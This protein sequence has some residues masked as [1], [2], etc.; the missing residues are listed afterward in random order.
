MSL[1][2]A[3]ALSTTI[4]LS[5]AT[6]GLVCADRLAHPAPGAAEIP[7][8]ARRAALPGPV[9]PAAPGTIVQGPGTPAPG[10][11]RTP[12][13]FDT[14]RLNALMRGETLPAATRRR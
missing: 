9:E 3:T 10:P 6:V 13:G 2:R 7:A 14:E 12:S 4:A 1:L 8:P 11:T 5:T